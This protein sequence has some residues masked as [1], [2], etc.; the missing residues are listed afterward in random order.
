MSQEFLQD[1][2]TEDISTLFSHYKL[3]NSMGVECPVRVYKQDAPIRQGDDEE[4]DKE[5]PP[6][7]YII[8][9]VMGGNIQNESSP[10]VVEVVLLICVYDRDPERQGF[11]DSLHIVNEIYRR[12]A[13]NGVVGRRYVLQYPIKWVTHD[14]DT[15]PYYYAAMSLNFEGPAVSKEVPET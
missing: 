2:L 15:H 1:A 11:R 4:G 3:K 7:P 8:V 12:F 14:E 6:E 5:A 13:A 9:R 10:H